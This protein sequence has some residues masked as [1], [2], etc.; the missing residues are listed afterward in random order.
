MI[1]EIRNFLEPDEFNKV[2]NEILGGNFSWYLA[3]GIAMPHDGHNM[4]SH[5]AYAHNNVNSDF[6]NFCVPIIKKLDAF[7]LVRIKANFHWQTKEIIE[8]GHHNDFRNLK[9]KTDLHTAI[10]Y[11]NTNNG[12]TKFKST[13]KKFY[14]EEN[15]MVVFKA[16]EMHTG[17]SCTDKNFRVVVNFNYFPR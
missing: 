3:D 5:I 8:H 16:S 2:Q 4:L 9:D 14:S 17:S 1:K 10:Y 6:Y 15:K 12:Y 11:I 7:S 13:G